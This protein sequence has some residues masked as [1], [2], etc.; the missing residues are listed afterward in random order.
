MIAIDPRNKI[1]V[2]DTMMDL[3][4]AEKEQRA[5]FIVRQTPFRQ[6][7]SLQ[8]VYPIERQKTN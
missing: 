2:L 3:A 5:A 6:C 1:Q 8:R 7:T 4:T